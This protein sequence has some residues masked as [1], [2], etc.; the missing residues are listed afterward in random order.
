MKELVTLKDGTEAIL[1]TRS[2]VPERYYDRPLSEF[3]LSWFDYCQWIIPERWLVIQ[4]EDIEFCMIGGIL[5]EWPDPK[6]LAIAC[7]NTKYLHYNY[8]I[9]ENETASSLRFAS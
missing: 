1:L 9:P 4:T 8:F 3:D 6:Y 2:D 5:C 7:D